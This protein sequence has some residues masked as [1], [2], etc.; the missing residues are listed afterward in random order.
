MMVPLLIT[1]NMH[2]SCAMITLVQCCVVICRIWEKYL[3]HGEMVLW[4]STCY[5]LY[6]A[7]ILY[8]LD[9]WFSWQTIVIVEPRLHVLLAATFRKLLLC[10]NWL[11]NK[12]WTW[13]YLV[14]WDLTVAWESYDLGKLYLW[15]F[16]NFLSDDTYTVDSR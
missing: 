1:D 2:A 16:S 8:L 6:F 15:N 4:N 13:I 5:L 3:L 9:I 7:F 11:A 12:P 10:W 14:M